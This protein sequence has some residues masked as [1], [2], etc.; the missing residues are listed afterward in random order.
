MLPTE[1]KDVIVN[2]FTDN[3]S[4]F[5]SVYET[6][7]TETD[8]FILSQAA[9]LDGYEAYNDEVSWNTQ[10]QVVVNP[11]I[12]VLGN[13]KYNETQQNVISIGAGNTLQ[14]NISNVS[15]FGNDNTV[16]SGY[17]DVFLMSNSASVIDSN[18]VV[19]IQPSGSRVISGSSSNVFINPISDITSSDPTGSVYTGNLINQGTADFKDGATLT[20]SVDITGSLCVNGDCWPFGGG[21]GPFA[22][23]AS[24]ISVYDT[25][26]Q[27]LDGALTASVMTFNNVDF[28]RGI[29]LVSGSQFTISTPGAYN[30]AFSAQLDKT[31]NTKETTFIWLR[32]NGNDVSQSNT[33]VALQGSAADKQVAAWNFFLTGSAGDYWELAWTATSDVAFLNAVAAVPGVYPATPSVIATV[34]SMY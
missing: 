28:S 12:I 8:P 19:L 25:T 13:S 17:N 4:V 18:E 23:T 27:A 31:A 11:N 34:N 33:S 2:G 26:D 29:T 21:V 3:G 6:G 16:S 10:E 24:F 1:F 14:D 30:L 22:Q 9:A 32:K 20:G 5:Y 7:E 15:I